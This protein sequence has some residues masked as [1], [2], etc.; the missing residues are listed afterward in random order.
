MEKEAVKKELIQRLRDFEALTLSEVCEIVGVKRW[1]I[2]Q[3]AREDLSFADDLQA[4]LDNARQAMMDTCERKMAEKISEGDNAVLMFFAK[5]Q[6]RERGYG[7]R[8]DISHRQE[9]KLDL[10]EAARR[11]AFAMQSAIA[12]GKTIEGHF[13]EVVPLDIGKQSDKERGRLIKAANNAGLVEGIRGGK[14]KRG[15]AYS[16]E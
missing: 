6:G 16:K 1:E 12:N 11:I 13:S 3:M 8:L 7:D 15:K 9:V 5:T 2:V 14:A 10:D 4:A